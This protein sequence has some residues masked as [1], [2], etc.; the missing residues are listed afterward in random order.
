MRRCRHLEFCQLE[1]SRLRRFIIEAAEEVRVAEELAWQLYEWWN[2]AAATVLLETR[3]PTVHV[4]SL[5]AN[6]GAN[7]EALDD[8]RSTALMWLV[9]S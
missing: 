9:S 4:V 3:T 2:E 5:L 8:S 7:L 6:K 1:K